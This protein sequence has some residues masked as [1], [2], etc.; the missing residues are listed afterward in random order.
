MATDGAAHL[1]RLGGR[2]RPTGSA[3][4]AEARRY[5]ADVLRRRGF[6]V[7]EQEF[8]Y[9]QFPGRWATPTAGFVIPATG[10]AIVALRSAVDWWLPAAIGAVLVL[11]ALVVL[12]M[13]SGVLGLG[14]ARA[15][16]INLEATRKGG[17]EPAVWFVAHIDSKWQPVSMLVRVGGVIVV[18]VSAIGLELALTAWTS[19]IAD[20][21]ALLWLGGIPLMLSVV[22]DRNHGTL[23]NASG[24][25][26]VLQA[27]ELLPE[28]ANVG[29]LISDAEE[30]ALAGATAW[31]RG[32]RA[33]T[34]L[35]CDSVDDDGSLVVMYTGVAAAGACV[36]TRARRVGQ[37]GAASHLATA[38]GYT[39]RQRCVDARRL[40]DGDTQP[41]HASYAW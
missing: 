25:A 29:V 35:N 12:V 20:F 17:N 18:A 31:A 13:R 10:T 19:S 40:E 3:A 16:G 14:L 23:D 8:E 24:V 4:A 27:I 28:D 21:L 36:V 38:A 9:S 26:A 15:R 32:R 11:V 34:A 41:R 33:G 30:L 2:A 7:I 5:C 39:H 37:R 1:A 6:A 22:G